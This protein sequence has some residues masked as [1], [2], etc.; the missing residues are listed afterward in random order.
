MP[1]QGMTGLCL[2]T[3]VAT[4]LRS[5]AENADIGINDYLTTLLLGPSQSGE[6]PYTGPSQI[7]RPNK[8][9]HKTPHNSLT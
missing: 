7:W 4:L 1:K 9:L 5:K 3:E 2:K 6:S 8:L